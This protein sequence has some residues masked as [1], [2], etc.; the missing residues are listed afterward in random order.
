MTVPQDH[1]PPPAVG[2]GPV[3]DRRRKRLIVTGGIAVVVLVV[4]VASI[5][6]F[7]GSG[8]EAP[9]GGTQRVAMMN[10]LRLTPRAV[11]ASSTGVRSFTQASSWTTGCPESGSIA[12]WTPEGVESVF[13]STLPTAEVVA[14]LD[15]I[16]VSQGW[17]RKSLPANANHGL[18]A[19]WW[20]NGGNAR[21]AAATLSDA[22]RSTEPNAANDWTFD[23]TFKP[24]PSASL[25]S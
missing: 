14:Q 2:G 17:V 9:H 25:C 24:R 1:P 19:R 10:H 8:T 12:G 11:P 22:F 7:G 23:A 20:L 15:R 21:H 4:V 6:I 16:L 5:V 18:V 3:R 13:V